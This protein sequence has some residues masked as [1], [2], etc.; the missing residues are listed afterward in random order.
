MGSGGQEEG[1]RW[2]SSDPAV[3]ASLRNR[4]RHRVEDIGTVQSSTVQYST[5]RDSTV[6][7]STDC[8]QYMYGGV[9]A[10]ATSLQSVGTEVQYS[11]VQYS[12]SRAQGDPVPEQYGTLQHNTVQYST[13]QYSTVLHC[14][15]VAV[16]GVPE[17]FSL[18][19]ALRLQ[20]MVCVAEYQ[21]PRGAAAGA[22]GR[23]P[24]LPVPVGA[25]LMLSPPCSRA[26]WYAVH[27]TVQYSSSSVQYSAE[28]QTMPF[29]C[30]SLP[31]SC[32]PWD[33]A[34]SIVQKFSIACAFCDGLQARTQG[35]QGRPC[36]PSCDE[37]VWAR[38]AG[39]VTMQC[40]T[41]Q[42]STLQ[43]STIQRSTLQC[44]TE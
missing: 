44:S 22:G 28:Q 42:R 38:I 1:R 4:Y 40:S 19:S 14:S 35:E 31:S 2:H 8:V 34:A 32:A 24:G 23:A 18:D 29:S 11:A 16:Q 15:R 37:T 25:L 21:M 41:T 20:Q 13:V 17:A 10:V 7:D 36:P 39:T 33:A 27:R 43:C 3:A 9:P 6:Q 26:L 12:R 5:V 30:S